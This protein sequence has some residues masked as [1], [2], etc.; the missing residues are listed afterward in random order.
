MARDHAASGGEVT[1]R[2]LAL[3]AEVSALAGR[4]GARSEP[5][6][7]QAVEVA[8]DAMDINAVLHF[9]RAVLGY[10][11]RAPGDDGP[12]VAIKDPTR[13]ETAFWFQQMDEPRSERNRFHI[14]VIVPHEIAQE[15]IDAAVAAGGVMVTDQ[16]ARSWWV[17]AD[18][19]GNEACVCTWQDRE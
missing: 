2:D 13:I 6:A 5:L 15:R 7:R 1:D 8:I 18:Q 17:L 3:A 4:A 10:W 14:D 16:Y 12:A 11:T 19:E 9:W